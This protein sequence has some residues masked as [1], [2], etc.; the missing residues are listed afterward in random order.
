MRTLH[1][2]WPH[3]P[4][5]SLNSAH[6]HLKA[7]PIVFWGCAISFPQ[8]H[9]SQW[10]MSRN[11]RRKMTPHE[12]N[13]FQERLWEFPLWF[14]RLRTQPVSMRM[15]VWSL[16]AAAPIWLL[17]W[18]LPYTA[19]VAL[20]KQKTKKKKNRKDSLWPLQLQW[21]CDIQ[22]SLGDHKATDSPVGWH[23]PEAGAYV[24]AHLQQRP[25]PCLQL[26]EPQLEGTEKGLLSDLGTANPAWKQDSGLEID[27]IELTK[28]KQTQS[29]FQNQ[30]F[31]YQKGNM[32]EGRDE[33]GG[34]DWYTHYSI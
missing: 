11:L 18:E 1:C 14:S 7:P 8:R 26:K 19:G 25:P 20:K 34:W 21:G 2:C 3:H 31:V 27:T 32:L 6:I 13:A 12:H 16:A 22:L 24:L 30:T 28:Q 29:W 5:G 4:D 17:A 23:C 15:R 33:L 10:Q 9:R